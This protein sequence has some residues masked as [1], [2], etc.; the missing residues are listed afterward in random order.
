[1]KILRVFGIVLAVHAFAFI[2][3][4][5]NPG[6]STKPAVAAT[7]P[8]EPAPQASAPAITVPTGEPAASPLVVPP[9]T[10]DPNAPAVGPVV[11]SPTR[12][13]TSAAAALQAEP[14]KD[15][16]PATTITVGKGDNLWNIAKKH[17]ISVSN[18]A[19]TNGLKVSAVLQPGQKLIVPGKAPAP[20]PAS[21]A[22]STRAPA[23]K[24]DAAKAP[25]SGT[26]KHVV[27]SG[28]ALSTIARKYG[29]KQGDLAEAN[30]ITNPAQIRAGQELIIP[31]NR[32]P[33]APKVEKAAAPAAAAPQ[34]AAAP[35]VPVIAISSGDAGSEAAKPAAPLNV[36]VIKIDEPAPTKN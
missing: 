2:L 15:V 3:I 5:A 11:Y 31:G 19:S 26:V 35:S 14:V 10:F 33:K 6:C 32:A 34:P 18:L 4:F 30:N 8:A 13:N 25:A 1:M 21:S 17:G 12:P 20:A 24:T 9:S 28:E 23:A 27:Q 7:P 29:L 22:A 16:V 36:P